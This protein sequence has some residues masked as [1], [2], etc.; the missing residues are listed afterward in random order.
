M[1]PFKLKPVRTPREPLQPDHETLQGWE[2]DRWAALY[3]PHP[4]PSL[5]ELELIRDGSLTGQ[6]FAVRGPAATVGRFAPQTGP[7]D[8]DMGVL[9]DYERYQIGLPHMRL[10]LEPEGWWLEPLSSAYPTYVN[11]REVPRGGVRLSNGMIL[12]LGLVLFRV[13]TSPNVARL[14]GYGRTQGP[15]LHLKRDG[16][17]CGAVIELD[18]RP[19]V[20]GRQSP[21]TGPVDVDLNDL[22]D[23]QRIHVAR[24]HARV[25]HVEGRWYVE[26]L[27]ERCQL[28]VNRR[29]DTGGPISMFNGDE[30]ALGNVLFVFQDL[31]LH[32]DGALE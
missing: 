31:Q 20:L 16:A 23:H 10:G 27:S 6:I 7:V 26:R 18:E 12:A 17:P 14:S 15:S 9:Q 8:I 32:D 21:W 28:F 4:L 29:A 13:R 24:R 30:L 22:P 3:Q 19:L 5:L 11:D 25:F 2:N 1:Q